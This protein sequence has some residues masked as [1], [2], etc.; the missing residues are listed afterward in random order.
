MIEPILILYAVLPFVISIVLKIL[1]YRTG[2]AAQKKAIKKLLDERIGTPQLD[3]D[4]IDV[5]LGAANFAVRSFTAA[6]TLIASLI[7]LF[8]VALKYQH[9][10]VWGCFAVNVLLAVF[11]WIRVHKHT[12]T[13][14]DIWS[15]PVGEFVLWMAFLVDAIGLIASIT[16]S[17]LT[18]K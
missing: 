2:G 9:P 1:G 7:A 5:V 18:G 13:W 12:G 17:I 3:D 10:F 4:Q 15:L 16:G 8:I 6:S 11:V 14:H